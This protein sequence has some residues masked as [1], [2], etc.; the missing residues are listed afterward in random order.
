MKALI[1]EAETAGLW[2]LVSK[3]FVENTASRHMLNRMGFREIGIHER[4]A[5]LDG[6][7]KDVVLVE[8]LITSNMN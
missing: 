4:H 8:Y 2:K 1:L 5:K 3:V 7:W 6:I